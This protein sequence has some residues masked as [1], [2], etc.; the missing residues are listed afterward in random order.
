MMRNSLCAALLALCSGPVFAQGSAKADLAMA[1]V[2]A[3]GWDAAGF[4][5]LYDAARYPAGAAAV[6]APEIARPSEVS[7]AVG[8]APARPAAATD[9]R[10]V[11]PPPAETPEYRRT[12][13]ILLAH[14]EQTDRYDEI[15]LK[16]AQI[17]HLDARFL[18]AIVAAESEFLI[19]AV[20]P[21]G[22]RGLMQV[23]PRTAE[24]MGIPRERLAEPEYNIAAGAAYVAHLFQTAFRK[25]KLKGVRFHEAPMWLKQRI[26]A[27]YNAGPRFLFR[28]DGW[29]RQT[30]DYVRKVLLYYHSPVTDFRRAASP[31][32]GGPRLSATAS[33]GTLY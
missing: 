16:Y 22:A 23:M 28:H 32:E 27:A 11:V 19:A 9:L 25:Y 14:P 10:L 5:R 20:S 21:R 13:K 3:P 26:I 31:L 6:R 18:K 12:F 24:E 8:P 17:Y 1:A 30:R 33:S 15:I 4:M 29:Y 2:Q 7:F